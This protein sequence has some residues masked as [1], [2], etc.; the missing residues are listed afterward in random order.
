MDEIYLHISNLLSN[1]IQKLMILQ[2]IGALYFIATFYIF[3]L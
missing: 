2:K 1:N 3:I